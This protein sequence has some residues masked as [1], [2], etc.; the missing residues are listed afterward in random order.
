[1][2]LKTASKSSGDLGHALE[3]DHKYEY[4]EHTLPKATPMTPHPESTVDETRVGT[5]LRSYAECGQAIDSI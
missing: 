5:L 3:D 1:M 2:A 4:H